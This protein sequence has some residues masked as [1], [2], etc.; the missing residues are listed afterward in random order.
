V[1]ERLSTDAIKP[2]PS[3]GE[4][5]ERVE[6]AIVQA[7]CLSQPGVR[8]AKRP[9]DEAFIGPHG[10]VGDRHEA[11]LRRKPYGRGTAPNHRQ[12]HG[13]CTEEVN[14]ICADLGLPSLPF[15]ALGEN[16]RLS[17]LLL[18]KLPN[19]TELTLPSG[20]RLR[21]HQQTDP[22]VKAAKEL[23]QTYGEAANGFVKAAM[24][25]RGVVGQVLEPGAVR[26]GDIVHVHLPALLAT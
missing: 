10:F 9:V 16:L 21:L 8:V 20:A 13:V 22:C 23:A 1:T 5:W 3:Q 18:G 19:G 12:W 26:P 14:G 24:G 4:G 25:R 11:E 15:G 2:S 7:V 6:R 17:G